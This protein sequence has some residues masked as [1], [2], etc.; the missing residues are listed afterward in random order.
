[1]SF[2]DEVTQVAELKPLPEATPTKKEIKL[3]DQRLVNY[4][5]QK[6]KAQ[7]SGGVRPAA[8]LRQQDRRRAALRARDLLPRR[9]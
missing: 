1:M 7:G 6:L 4:V 8:G 5:C 2:E 9:R 3:T